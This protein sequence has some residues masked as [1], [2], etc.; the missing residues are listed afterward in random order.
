MIERSKI[1]QKMKKVKTIVKKIGW[2]CCFFKIGLIIGY[3]NIIIQLII[4]LDFQINQCKVSINLLALSLV[5]KV[6]SQLKV[7]TF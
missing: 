2:L 4:V 7:R 6:P 5:S 3:L 1:A